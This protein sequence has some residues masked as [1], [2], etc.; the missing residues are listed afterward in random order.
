MAASRRTFTAE[1]KAEAVRRVTE[2]SKSLAEVSC[3][4]DLGESLLR[5]WKRALATQGDQAFPCKGNLPPRRGG[6]PTAAGREPAAAGRAGDFQI[7]DGLLRQGVV[8]RYQFIEAQRERWPIRLL[9]EVLDVSPGGFY[10]WRRRPPSDS[11]QR[12]GALVAGTETIHREV[13]A[14]D[15]SPRIHVEL[16][17]R[18]ESCSVNTV[19]RLMRRHGI[20]AKTRRR[21]R[22]TTDSNHD[23]PVAANLVDR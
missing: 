6:T 18:G 19:A 5:D 3:E 9:C 13:K 11:H 17:A 14:R 1:F 7:S 12:R 8:V 15:G 2:G 4:L 10:D 16:V 22:S 21:F 23:R 20:A